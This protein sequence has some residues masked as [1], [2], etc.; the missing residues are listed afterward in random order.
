MGN[1]EFLGDAARVVDVLTGTTGPL[2]V[3][4]GTVVVE[5]Q[6]DPD[7]LIAFA[8]EH[9]G[10]DRRIDATRHCNNNAGLLRTASKIE[11][12]QHTSPPHRIA[13]RAW[14]KTPGL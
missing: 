12:I 1:A 7:H 14:I 10:D 6:R 3:S 4:R 8:L 9:A 2:A 5:L 13:V 11:A